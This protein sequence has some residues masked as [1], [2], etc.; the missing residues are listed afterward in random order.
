MISEV[1]KCAKC[2]LSL[3][4]RLLNTE[5][6]GWWRAGQSKEYLRTWETKTVWWPGNETKLTLT[7]CT[8]NSSNLIIQ[9]FYQTDSQHKT[10]QVLTL[11]TLPEPNHFLFLRFGSPNMFKSRYVMSIDIIYLVKCS[12]EKCKLCNIKPDGQEWSASLDWWKWR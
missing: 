2:T 6:L 7:H 1:F 9:G 8:L 12:W 4:P 5:A 10:A 3:I 11:F